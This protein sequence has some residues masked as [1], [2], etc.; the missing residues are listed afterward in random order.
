MPG[1]A[2][3]DVSQ[4]YL[5]EMKRMVEENP[6]VPVFC[7]SWKYTSSNTNSSCDSTRFAVGHGLQ[8]ALDLR[9]NE[10]LSQLQSGSGAPHCWGKQHGKQLQVI[11]KTKFGYFF[12]S[13]EERDRN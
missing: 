6:F 13:W 3:G 4:P 12:I 5:E 11:L 2:M 10:T 9:L 7:D 1:G 8:M